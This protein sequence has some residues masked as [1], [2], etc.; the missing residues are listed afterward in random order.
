MNDQLP[1]FTPE[2]AT[3][4]PPLPNDAAEL[5]Q[6]Y[7]D[8]LNR[9]DALFRIV[10]MVDILTMGHPHKGMIQLNELVKAALK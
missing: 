4:H 10:T 6:L 1:L 5:A 2:T 8:L 7:A 3:E 9:Y